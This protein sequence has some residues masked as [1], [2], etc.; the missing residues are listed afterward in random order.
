MPEVVNDIVRLVIQYKWWIAP[1]VPFVIGFI[2]VKYL[3]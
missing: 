1:L 2:V 3:S